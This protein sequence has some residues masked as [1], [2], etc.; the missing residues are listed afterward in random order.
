MGFVSIP[1]TRPRRWIAYDPQAVLSPLLN[2]KAAILAVTGVPSQRS[3][4]DKLQALQLKREVAGTS[5][6]E[7]AEFTEPELD[8]AL[9]DG[10]TGRE[11]RSQ[12]QAAAAMRAYR[13]IAGLPVETPVSRELLLTLHRLVVTGCDDDHGP[14]GA[15]RGPGANVVFGTPRHRGVAGG[16]ECS[17]AFRALC[18][19]THDE[20]RAHDA[21]VQALALH[22]HLAA[23]HP[24]VDGNGRTARAAEALVLRGAGLRD[25]ASIAMSNYYYDH[26]TEYLAALDATRAAGH[27]LTPFLRFALAGIEKQCR[28][29]IAE[30]RIHISR[31]L[32]RDTMR[33]LFSRLRTPRKRVL[34][35]R[36]ILLTN[37]IVERGPV[38][39]DDLLETTRHLYAVRGRRNALV[40]DLLYLVKLGA[41]TLDSREGPAGETH[42]FE[43]NLDWPTQITETEFFRTAQRLPKSKS[44]RPR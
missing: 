5:R 25:V 4:A 6:I 30:Y 16:A 28:A 3:W 11:T 32:V 37:L 15:L 27:D 14:P 26:K 39:F 8:A 17:R 2:A 12:R 21:L 13:W 29:L 9:R 42:R 7:G 31:A 22:Y 1:Y 38:E 33:D 44:L 41:L 35:E 24:F 36:H 23:M 19:A 10:P 40:R 34:G 20:F 18:E 43:V